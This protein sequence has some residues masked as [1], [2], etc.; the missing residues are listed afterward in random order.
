MQWPIYTF[1]SVSHGN[2]KMKAK[3]LYSQVLFKKLGLKT[4]T[5][6]DQRIIS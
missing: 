2:E 3:F 6:K 4:I 1:V 5:S